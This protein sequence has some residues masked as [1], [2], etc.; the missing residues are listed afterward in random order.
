M[1]NKSIEELIR[2]LDENNFIFFMGDINYS[3]LEIT[4]EILRR[5]EERDGALE[6]IEHYQDEI[7][8]LE[9]KIK[10]LENEK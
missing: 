8:K 10:E 5:Y 1:K 7:T 4:R 2:I 3:S 6:A 9:N